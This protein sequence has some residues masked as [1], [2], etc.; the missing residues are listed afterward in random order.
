M[1]LCSLSK[2]PTQQ[3]L[4]P[5][6]VNNKGVWNNT[7]YYSKNDAVQTKS[8]V[9]AIAI[10]D[11]INQNPLSSPSVWSLYSGGGGGGGG[12]MPI[13]V[14]PSQT[15]LNPMSNASPSN[16]VY[17]T[18]SNTFSNW[19]GGDGL[20]NL[21]LNGSVLGVNGTTGY[22][23]FAF[24]WAWNRNGAGYS[25]FSPN[26]GNIASGIPINTG[27][28]NIIGWNLTNTLYIPN[29]L[30]SDSIEVQVQI[31]R[32]SAEPLTYVSFSAQPF[33]GFLTPISQ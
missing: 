31:N 24:Q 13:F 19:T 5:D 3:S 29:L 8:G 21:T 15:T 7:T 18:Y 28:S 2:K 30:S 26:V 22:D 23:A 20:L 16:Y 4:L 27:G 11:N 12:Q 10:V 33:Q 25:N 9:L 17:A 6:M 14:S 32:T 1:S